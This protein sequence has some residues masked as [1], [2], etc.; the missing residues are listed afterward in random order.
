M[1]ERVRPPESA[2]ERATLSGML[3]FLRQTVAYKVSGLTDE[4]AFAR[5][6][7]TTDLTAAGLVKHLT[8][9]ERFWFAIDFAAED[10]DWPWTDENPHGNF[11]LDPDDT[12]TAIVADYQAECARSRAITAAHSLDTPAKSPGMTFTLRYAVTH[13]IE[14]TARHLGHLDLLREA[15]DGRTGE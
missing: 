6:I 14:E 4:Q 11:R 5:P 2:D 13:L 9:V 7:G 10:V 12:L 15:T 3:D 1:D 8:G